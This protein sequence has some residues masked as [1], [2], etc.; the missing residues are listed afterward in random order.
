MKNGRMHHAPSHS[1]NQIWY[2]EEKFCLFE[3]EKLY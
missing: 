2:K 1:I 3:E